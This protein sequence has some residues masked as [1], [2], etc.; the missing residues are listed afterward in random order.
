MSNAVQTVQ[1][2]VR[3]P[4]VPKTVKGWLSGDYFRQQVAL[5]LPKHMTAERFVRVALSALGRIPKLASC[6]PESVVKCMMTCSELGLEPDGRRAH[7]IPYGT[8]CTLIVDYK[9]LVELAMR[10]GTVSSIFANIV[11]DADEFRYLTGE[12]THAIDFRKPRGPMYAVY[13]IVAFKDGGKHTEVMTRED[14][15]RIRARSKAGRQGP[16]VTDYDEMAKKTVFRRA[17]KWVT[18][19]PEVQDALDRQDADPA[20]TG[21]RLVGEVSAG[22]LESGPEPVAGEPAPI[23]I[24]SERAQAAPEPSTPVQTPPEP[25][26]A[27]QAAPAPN[28]AP[29]GDLHTVQETLAEVIVNAGFSF[30]H[31]Q[32]WCVE[33]GNIPEADSL[34]AFEDV[35]A[36]H[37]KRLLRAQ[38]GLLKGL[39]MVKDQEGGVT[40]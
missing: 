29:P 19:S 25:S 13:C 24:A 6:T 22:L 23:E 15:D 3:Q 10:S 7:L 9:G 37:C 32:K 2:T 18:L 11:C 40:P 4:V 28:L 33:T 16:W 14:V 1:T 12:I 27:P 8:E 38:V 30:S 5:V 20:P 21:S 39:Q 35:P 26:D 34:P 31:F 36:N 17:S